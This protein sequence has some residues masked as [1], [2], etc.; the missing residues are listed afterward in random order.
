MKSRKIRRGEIY[1]A[2]LSPIIGSEQG[3]SRPVLIVSNNMGNKYGPTVVIT[4]I[5]GN[6]KKTSLPTH[7]IIP[8]SSGIVTDSLVLV[9][10]I[11][12][13]DRSRLGGYIGRIGS[14]VQSEI[15]D[16]LAIC[17]GIT[18]CK[19]STAKGE[20]L[21]LCL[22]HHCEDSFKNSGYIV[23]KKGWQDSKEDC[24]FCATR[25]GFTFGI[26]GVEKSSS[27][28]RDRQEARL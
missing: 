1:Y 17:V 8:L 26:F 19:N 16:A 4:P 18:G 5:T 15:D 9:E 13:I 6:L 11:R 23:I 24:D 10:Q 12:T 3:D 22:C 2:N 14:D 27:F 25:R 7:V 20:I 21:T 28:L